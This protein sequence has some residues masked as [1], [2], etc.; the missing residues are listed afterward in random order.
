MATSEAATGAT[1]VA[2]QSGW[3]AGFFAML[4]ETTNMLEQAPVV[5]FICMGMLGAFAGW[6]LSIESGK[7]D[8][9]PRALQIRSLF[10]RFGIG[11]AIGSAIGVYWLDQPAGA[12]RGLWMLS[13]GIIAAAPVDMFRVAIDIVSSVLRQRFGAKNDDGAGKSP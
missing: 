6:A 5:G 11:V 3:V 7:F 2:A 4:V 10:L 1:V 13:A 12:S 9:V 8:E